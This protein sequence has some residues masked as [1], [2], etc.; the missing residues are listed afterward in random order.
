MILRCEIG[1][2]L[3]G[4]EVEAADILELWNAK[5]MKYL[6][7]DTPSDCKD[8]CLQD[9]NWNSGLFGNFPTYTL[10][11]MMAAQIFAA[12]RRAIGCDG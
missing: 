8:G 3:V 6:Q 11:A 7:R 4:G 9:V 1:K 12:A 10:G 2:A 5:M